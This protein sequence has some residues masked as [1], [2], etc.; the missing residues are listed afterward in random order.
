MVPE[1]KITLVRTLYPTNVGSTARSMA[2]MGTE[3]LILVDPQCKINLKARQAAAKAQEELRSHR[4][5]ASWSEYLQQEPQDLR[6]AFT[7]RQGKLRPVQSFDECLRHIFE[8]KTYLLDGK[9]AGISLIFGPEDSGLTNEDI[10]QVHYCCLLPTFG[11]NVSLNLSQAAL[12]AQLIYR[13]EAIKFFDEAVKPPS[14]EQETDEAAPFPD[15]ALVE[16]LELLGLDLSHTK[17]NAY[18]TMKRL[19]LNQVPSAKELR[20]LGSVI[21]Q[22]IRRLKQKKS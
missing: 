16:W 4:S 17:T 15:Q 11:T 19:I 12:V 9:V 6:I 18:N 5:Y 7:A 8:E 1:L 14:T 20:V 3:R 21:Q 13:Q 22:T 10:D 2:N